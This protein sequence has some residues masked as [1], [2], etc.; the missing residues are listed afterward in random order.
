MSEQASKR[1]SMAHDPSPVVVTDSAGVWWLDDEPPIRESAC[2]EGSAKCTEGLFDVSVIEFIRDFERDENKLPCSYTKSRIT[3]QTPATGKGCSHQIF[4]QIA[5]LQKTLRESQPLKN[6]L[7]LYSRVLLRDDC[8]VVTPVDVIHIESIA[9]VPNKGRQSSLTSSLVTTGPK[10]AHHKLV[11]SSE[12][13]PSFSPLTAP[14]PSITTPSSPAPQPV[15]EPSSKQRSPTT[16]SEEPEKDEVIEEVKEKKKNTVDE[17]SNSRE[18]K[19]GASNNATSVPSPGTTKSSDRSSHTPTGQTIPPHIQI[20][21]GGQQMH[22]TVTEKNAPSLSGA[23]QRS[24]KRLGRT[25]SA[26]STPSPTPTTASSRKRTSR[27]TSARLSSDGKS[28]SQ[29]SATR[30]NG[31]L[32]PHNTVTVKNST[33]GPRTSPLRLK[34]RP[35]ITRR[36]EPLSPREYTEVFEYVEE[37][38]VQV[39]P[40]ETPA[41]SKTLVK[42]RIHDDPLPTLSRTGSVPSSPM[43]LRSP[44]TQTAPTVSYLSSPT[45]PHTTYTSPPSRTY[46]GGI[47]VHVTPPPPTSTATTRPVN[48]PMSASSPMASCPASA[49]YRTPSSPSVLRAPVS[50]SRVLSSPVYSKEISDI[51]RPPP[52]YYSEGSRFISPPIQTYTYN[53]PSQGMTTSST[54]YS[55]PVRPPT[56]TTTAAGPTTVPGANSTPMTRFDEKEGVAPSRSPSATLSLPIPAYN[57]APMYV[58]RTTPLKDA[59]PSSISTNAT[60]TLYV[61]ADEPTLSN[62]PSS[63][64]PSFAPRVLDDSPSKMTRDSSSP[65]ARSMVDNDVTS[66]PNSSLSSN[67]GGYKQTRTLKIR[68]N[69]KVE[70]KSKA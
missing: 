6:G 61:R 70:Y 12:E 41:A 8:A 31:I 38:V 7:A 30:S 16:K 25:M 64:A 60:P 65:V 55:S 29:A 11:T 69:K 18:A 2:V 21:I 37:E 43:M 50:Y 14:S 23:L 57:R 1:L 28:P 27:L 33:I 59:S 46:S 62:S 32:F 4:H 49:H 52:Y 56:V 54:F 9:A 36:S 51:V 13:S 45:P 26:D 22:N 47:P 58:H 68:A 20:S 34:R 67:N 66:P 63:T 19:T 53:Q 48:V 17:K 35:P 5:Q 15:Q 10:I 44:H 40:S 3:C 42:S 24:K 39:T